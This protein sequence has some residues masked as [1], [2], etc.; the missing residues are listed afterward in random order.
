MA[1][2]R[3]DIKN[4]ELFPLV[5]ERV[6]RLISVMRIASNFASSI[7]RH[8]KWHGEKPLSRSMKRRNNDS[9]RAADKS[10]IGL[11]RLQLYVSIV[12]ANRIIEKTVE[13]RKRKRGRS[14]QA[15]VIAKGRRRR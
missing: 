12:I 7:T 5:G 9:R 2:T 3:A 8:I 11:Q 10:G 15:I 6:A 1:K 14:N 4:G 13:L